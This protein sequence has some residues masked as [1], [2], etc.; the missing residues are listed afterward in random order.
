MYF[1]C[2]LKLQSVPMQAGHELR[3]FIVQQFK[4]LD[5][6]SSSILP[7][8]QLIEETASQSWKGTVNNTGLIAVL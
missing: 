1:A 7:W 6:K 3:F 2:P 4:T 8:T 5:Q